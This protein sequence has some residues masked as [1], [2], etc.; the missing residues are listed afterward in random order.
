MN[1]TTCLFTLAVAVLLSMPSWALRGVKEGGGDDAVILRC[2]TL[3][4]A[5]LEIVGLSYDDSE[6]MELRVFENGQLKTT[7][8]GSWNSASA[9]YIGYHFELNLLDRRL[10]TMNGFTLLDQYSFS[11]LKCSQ[12]SL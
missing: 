9:N 11:N 5:K 7:D 2:H 6:L 1:P 8:Y 4:K 12:A 3:S 10:V